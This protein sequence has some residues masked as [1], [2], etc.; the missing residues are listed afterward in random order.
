VHRIERTIEYQGFQVESAPPKSSWSS[1]SRQRGC[2]V[3]PCR[4]P[5]SRA[6]TG[7]SN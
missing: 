3:W 7:W 2:S 4:R 1:T 6:P 5:C